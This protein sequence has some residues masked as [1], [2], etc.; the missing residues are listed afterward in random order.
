MSR[1][2]LG[3]RS[4]AALRWIA[5]AGGVEVHFKQVPPYERA[6]VVN[7]AHLLEAMGLIVDHFGDPRLEDGGRT[8]SLTELGRTAAELLIWNDT[9][10]P[11]PGASSGPTAPTTGPFSFGQPT[12]TNTA[13]D[14]RPRLARAPATRTPPVRPH[15]TAG[16][17][18][19]FRRRHDV[20][21]PRQPSPSSVRS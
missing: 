20:D 7:T 11:P 13:A 8:Y 12:C 10:P 16:R 5:A 6:A 17:P 4:E 21:G 2:Q 19:L 9:S 14:E 3:K 1:N 15:L 18:A